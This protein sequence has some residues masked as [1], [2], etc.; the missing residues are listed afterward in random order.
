MCFYL[1]YQISRLINYFAVAGKYDEGES[2]NDP[3]PSGL[4]IL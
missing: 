2:F 4:S 1:V 3:C